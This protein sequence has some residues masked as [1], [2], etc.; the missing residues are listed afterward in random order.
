MSGDGDVAVLLG[1]YH[2]LSRQI[3][4]HETDIAGLRHKQAMLIGLMHK[5]G[6]S[7]RVLAP[8]LGISK[9]RVQ[10]LEAEPG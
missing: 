1:M 9:S 7:Y 8:M 3:G 4:Q 10:Q 2:D 6:L 5:T